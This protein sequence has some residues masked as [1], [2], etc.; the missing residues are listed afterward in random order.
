MRTILTFI[1]AGISFFSAE[2]ASARFVVGNGGDAIFCQKSADNKLDGYYALDY[3]VTL[4]SKTGDDGLTNVASWDKSSERIYNLLLVKAPTM[5]PYFKEFRETVFNK[6]YSK[7]KVWEP[8]PFGLMDLD[9]QNITSLIPE[10]CKKDGKVQITQA[11]IRQFENY[12]G[13][14]RGHTIYKYDPDIVSSLDKKSPLQLSFLMVHEW[15]WDLSQNVD[16]NRRINRF[17]HSKEIESMPPE[18][19][20][21]NL[22][23]MGLI[24]PNVQAELFDDNICQGEPMKESDFNEHYPGGF[25]MANWG[26]VKIEQRQRQISCPSV[27][28][29]CDTTWKPLS[30]PS[31]VFTKFRFSLSPNWVDNNRQYPLKILSP[32]FFGAHGGHF[33]QGYGQL[34]CRFVKDATQNLECKIDDSNLYYPIFGNISDPD[35]KDAQSVV[36]KALLTT[37][38][39]RLKARGHISSD[40][41]G[42]DGRGGEFVME[43]ETVFYLHAADGIFLKPR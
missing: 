35:G 21:N 29:G 15:L 1:L 4:A 39:F 12:S 31:D 11:V 33:M 17:L 14:E 24:I 32:D 30:F 6:D 13:T 3:V 16:R 37:E 7:T 18:V 19:V 27:M 26:T 23:G 9:D 25:V 10:N 20:V 28:I 42:P 36:M 8:T 5:A 22:K 41:V 2:M 40:V 34:S 43:Q 38:C